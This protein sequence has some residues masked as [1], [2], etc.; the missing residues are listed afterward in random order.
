MIICIWLANRHICF[1]DAHVEGFKG[2]TGDTYINIMFHVLLVFIWIEGNTIQC[3]ISC[4]I[5]N[6]LVINSNSN[7]RTTCT[8]SY[9]GCKPIAHHKN[10]RTFVLCYKDILF[11]K[12]NVGGRTLPNF[13]AT[14]KPVFDTQNF[15]FSLIVH[16]NDTFSNFSMLWIHYKGTIDIHW[17]ENK[18]IFYPV[19]NIYF[20]C[21]S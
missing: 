5:G 17:S 1:C 20:F 11:S 4:R 19:S 8:I 15:S 9:L 3:C 21:F 2:G 16:I 12:E 18:E 10:S 14:V 6:V 7:H 13:G